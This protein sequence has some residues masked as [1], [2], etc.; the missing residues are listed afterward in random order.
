LN[1]REGQNDDVR[2][3]SQAD[4]AVRLSDVRFTSNSGHR[5]WRLRDVGRDPP[6]LIRI[7]SSYFKAVIVL[8]F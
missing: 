7:P 3:G 6:R 4:I 1:L 5:N 8:D 2:F